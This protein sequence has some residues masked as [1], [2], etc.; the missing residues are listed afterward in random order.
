MDYADGYLYPHGIQKAV[1]KL[2]SK[3]LE[4]MTAWQSKGYMVHS[5][6]VRFIVAWKAKDAPREETETAVLL[7]E[8]T[9]KKTQ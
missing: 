7:P 6:S 3:M 1:A 4:H 8:L 9:L 5:A 2:S